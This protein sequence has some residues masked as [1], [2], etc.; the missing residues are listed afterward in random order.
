MA[1]EYLKNKLW[2]HRMDQVFALVSS[3]TDKDRIS[4]KDW[5]VWVDNLSEKKGCNPDSKAFRNVRTILRE[6][7]KGMSLTPGREATLDEF[8]KGVAEFAVVERSKL[9]K[10]ELLLSKLNNAWYDAVAPGKDTLALE[11]YTMLMTACNF[12]EGH[13]KAAF[14]HLDKNESGEVKRSALNDSEFNFWFS[15][16]GR[17]QTDGDDPALKSMGMFGPDFEL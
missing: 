15:L 1:D 11:E 2:C 17:V 6:F 8:K 5:E 4:L 10:E 14:E 13:A 7:C 16:V 9:G 3:N 12:R